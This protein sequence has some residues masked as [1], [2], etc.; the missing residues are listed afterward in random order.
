LS[1]ATAALTL[2]EF[3][4]LVLNRGAILCVVLAT[5]AIAPYAYCV[6]F[7]DA[8]LAEETSDIVEASQGNWFAVHAQGIVAI[9][10]ASIEFG[11]PFNV[12]ALVL[13]PELFRVRGSES[14]HAAYRSLLARSMLIGIA[15]TCL[16]VLASDATIFKARWML[17]V[18]MLFPF[19]LFAGHMRTDR[20]RTRFRIYIAA[21][22]S[23]VLAS[24]IARFAVDYW[25][26]RT[27]GRCRRTLPVAALQTPLAQYDSDDYV[28]IARKHHIAGNLVLLFPNA[29][30]QTP[31]YSQ[32]TTKPLDQ[33]TRVYVWLNEGSRDEEEIREFIAETS[34][35]V[36]D[37]IAPDMTVTAR[38]AQYPERSVEF[39]CMTL[40]PDN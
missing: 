14:D 40:P 38:F 9:V 33:K 15:I 39:C 24:M 10:V 6:A 1:L 17:P 2:K 36:V 37:S 4:P 7:C 23:F 19:F 31:E 34:G 3:R 29:V 22:G 5:A 13:F 30:I 25:E 32:W 35:R 26:P 12:V 18:L 16:V 21:V 11:L 28:F 8:S 27:E 20:Q